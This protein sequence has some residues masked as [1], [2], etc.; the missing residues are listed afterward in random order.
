MTRTICSSIEKHASYERTAHTQVQ[1]Q[2]DGWNRHVEENAIKPNDGPDPVMNENK[3]FHAGLMQLEH[4]LP[5]S[6]QT[7][8]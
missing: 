8:W 2:A 3:P 7:L 6:V 5:K 4:I 1:R